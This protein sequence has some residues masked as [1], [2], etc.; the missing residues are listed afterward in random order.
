MLTGDQVEP[1]SRYPIQASGGGLAF[2]GHPVRCDRLV[3]SVYDHRVVRPGGPECVAP[4]V[5]EVVGKRARVHEETI[6]TRVKT[7]AESVGVPVARGPV[8]HGT[9]VENQLGIGVLPATAHH[10]IT[11]IAIGRRLMTGRTRR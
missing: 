3:G 8:A 9:A 4:L 11:T 7:K 1:R 6:S 2:P 5:I 10:V